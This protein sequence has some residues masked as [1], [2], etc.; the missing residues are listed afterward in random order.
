LVEQSPC[1]RQAVGSSPTSGSA[2][3]RVPVP[4]AGS[5][6]AAGAGPVR[7]QRW[8]AALLAL[9]LAW[10]AAGCGRGSGSSQ[11]AGGAA[12]KREALGRQ[13]NPIG[14]PGRTLGLARVVIPPGARLPLHR[15]EGTQVAYVQS[16]TL[17]YTV[18]RGAVAVMRGSADAR[19][20]P[21]RRITAGQTASIRAGQ[22]LVEEPADIH[23]AA[24]RGSAP[25]V[26]LLATLLRTG[27]PPATPVA[28]LA[29]R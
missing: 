7:P 25:V 12:A 11:P 9:A 16:G 14:A 2:D 17:S 19:P 5:P 1:K 10:A 26:V 29:S 8:A 20:A 28:R 18:V 24:N 27:A 15:H 23:R 3:A 22:W 13:P 6:P 21:V 4:G